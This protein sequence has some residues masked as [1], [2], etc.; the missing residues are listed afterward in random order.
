M[1]NRA[2]DDRDGP[3]GVVFGFFVSE[4]KTQKSEFTGASKASSELTRIVRM[5]TCPL[6]L[7]E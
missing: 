3:P 4:E 5:R 2:D 7:T 1:A 6:Y